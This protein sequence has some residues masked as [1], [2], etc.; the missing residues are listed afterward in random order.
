MANE[1][2]LSSSPPGFARPWIQALQ[3]MFG[4]MVED[5]ARAVVRP[6]VAIYLSEWG[7]TAGSGDQMEGYVERLAVGLTYH[8]WRFAEAEP[9]DAEEVARRVRAGHLAYGKFPTDVL[10]ELA[11]AEGLCRL[12]AGATKVFLAEFSETIAAEL[13]RLGGG[14]DPGEAEAFLPDLILPRNGRAPKLAGFHGRTVLKSWLRQVVANDW[15]DR[16]RSRGREAPLTDETPLGTDDH[17]SAEDDAQHH[18]CLDLI[19]GQG[20]WAINALDEPSS[21]T[22]WQMVMIDGTPQTE[23]AEF[24]GVHKSTISRACAKVTDLFREAMARLPSVSGCIDLLMQAS[25][26]VRMAFAQ[27]F[28]EALRESLA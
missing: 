6:L 21:L 15:K 19:C 7:T 22:I 10:R 28:V 8:W 2:N 24:Y 16:L 14:A 5:R 13:R 9:I 25:R 3:A 27:R 4:E 12:D 1:M 26:P 20:R 18:E 17:P 11:L 23:V